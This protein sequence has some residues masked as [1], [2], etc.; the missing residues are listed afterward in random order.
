MVTCDSLQWITVRQS[1]ALRAW[2]QP[3]HMGPRT[4]GNPYEM[5]K[6]GLSYVSIHTHNC[7]TPG[8]KILFFCGEGVIL[9]HILFLLWVCVQNRTSVHIIFEKCIKV[10][11][12]K[13]KLKEPLYFQYRHFDEFWRWTINLV[14][15]IPPHCTDLYGNIL[16][17]LSSVSNRLWKLVLNYWNS[18]S[19]ISAQNEIYSGREKAIPMYSIIINIYL[20]NIFQFQS[21]DI[22]FVNKM[23]SSFSTSL[24]IM[25]Y[26]CYFPC[27]FEKNNKMFKVIYSSSESLTFCR[28]HP[29]L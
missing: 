14:R 27:Y 25:W 29:E 15:R 17:R 12:K 28:I 18:A 19:D 8:C 2:E 3:K 10:C 24:Y 23:S 26:I 9:C 5:I 4:T 6:K 7:Q 1:M 22:S 11:K 13:K 16:Y 21:D 20:L